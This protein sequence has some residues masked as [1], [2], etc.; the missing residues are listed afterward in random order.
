MMETLNYE[1]FYV[2]GTYVDERLGIYVGWVGHPDSQIA[3]LPLQSPDKKVTVVI[4]GE[5]FEANDGGTT[6]TSPSLIDRY[7][8]SGE[9]AFSQLN[10]SFA[11][12]LADARTGQIRLFND[13]LGFERLYWH[14]E[15]NQTAFYFSSE[16]K[17]LLRVLPSTREFDRTGL[18]QFLRYGC[19]F[20]E[21]TLYRNISLLPP[22]SVWTIHK[23]ATLAPHKSNYF[24]PQQWEVDPR[25]NSNDLSSR[26]TDV[27]QN[28]LPKYFIG[29]SG[30]S[31]TGGWDTRMILAGHVPEPQRLPCYTFAGP[32]RDTVDV[33][34]ARKV[35]KALQQDH[36]VL[37]LQ[38]DFFKDF[39][40]HAEK[41]V[42]V[43]DGYAGICLSHEI[44]L[45]RKARDVAAIRV[46]GNFGSEILRGVTTFKEI[47]L[48]S[49]WFQGDLGEDLRLCRHQWTDDRREEQSPA[50]FAV[51][52][53]IPW[54]L[55][56]TARL[57]NSQIQFRSP[58]M[59]LEVLR[60]ACLVPPTVS[61]NS[62][63]IQ[64]VQRLKPELLRVPTDQGESASVYSA[65]ETLRRLWYKGTFKLD[66]YTYE[67]TFGLFSRAIDRWKVDRLLP[68]QHRYLH[69]RTWFGATLKDY[70]ND[71]LGSTNGFALGLIGGKRMRE[72]L[73]R[74]SSSK[75]GLADLNALV[76]IDLIHRHLLRATNH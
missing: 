3:A 42:F 48:H 51:F 20:H 13:R 11:G 53:E 55:A 9:L 27:F 75:T 68:T 4:S 6:G 30:L 28:A 26:F 35:A 59:D 23:G 58:F 56:T 46:T 72:T 5:L 43:S 17:A 2:T 8:K 16:A 40:K 45:N 57:A 74:H 24:S 18:A 76:S 50:K 14:Q 37:R 12:L 49:D 69:Y 25:I 39:G 52:V 36:Q 31:L 63:P 1:P 10:G 66:Y 44:Y 38:A 61:G 29:Q 19:T 21:K 7:D 33:Q 32:Q 62:L 47:H 54:R 15:S 70:V 41:T 71:V 65:S 64:F 67:G 34:Q 73:S 22:A 60:L